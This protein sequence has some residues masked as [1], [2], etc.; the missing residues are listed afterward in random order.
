MPTLTYTQVRDMFQRA[1]SLP[2]N[3]RELVESALYAVGLRHEVNRQGEDFIKYSIP[4]AQYNKILTEA[5][6]LMAVSDRC[7]DRPLAEWVR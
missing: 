4:L 5:A 3:N 7:L 6:G 2:G 1:D